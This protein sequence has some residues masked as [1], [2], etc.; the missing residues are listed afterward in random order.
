[1]TPKPK[2]T[3]LKS[4]YVLIEKPNGKWATVEIKRE[5]PKL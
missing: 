1:M 2:T 5:G 3:L 4:D